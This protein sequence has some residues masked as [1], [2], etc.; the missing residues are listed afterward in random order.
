MQASRVLGIDRGRT[1]G[2]EK[3]QTTGASQVGLRLEAT[4]VMAWMGLGMAL[5]FASFGRFPLRE[6]EALYGYWARL[7]QSGLDPMLERVAVD[8][9]PFFIY[10][11]ANVFDWLGPTIASARLLNEFCSLLSMLFLWMLARRLYGPKTSVIALALFALSPFA[12][13]FAPTL[14]TDPMLLAWLLL[15]MLCAAYRFGLGAG[16][17]LGMAFAT[18]QNALLFIPLILSLLFLAPSRR[19]LNLLHFNLPRFLAPLLRLFTFA[20][21]FYFVWFKVWQWDGWR[22]LP[23]EIPSF[24]QQSWNSYGGLDWASPAEW[25]ARAAE[26]AV[27]WQWLGGWPP[28]TL[29]LLS[30]CVLAILHHSRNTRTRRLD[31]LFALFILAYLIG[32]IIVGFQPWDRYLLPLTPLLAMLAA[33]GIEAGWERLAG[34]VNLRSGLVIALVLALGWGTVQSAQARIPVGGDHGAYEGI[35]SVAAYLRENVPEKNGVLYQHWL[36]WHWNWYLWDGPHGRVYWADP[37]MLVADL[38]KH[39]A[40]YTRFVVF[41]SWELNEREPLAAALTPI[42]F[43]LSERLTVHRANDN[44]VQFVV[45]EIVHIPSTDFAD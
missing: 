28:G 15:A 11:L 29:I 38:S 8:K 44:G 24:W 35:E 43:Q 3:E 45:Y 4:W 10:I 2:G 42:G 34:G 25:P 1:T 13:A 37:A 7:V 41:P 32:H 27:V 17:A 33:R 39:P 16:L 18:K 23:A 22:I 30:L 19:S 36:G 21:G 12:I 40:G 9:P 14:Y 5:R 26:W 6:D 31:I 20:A